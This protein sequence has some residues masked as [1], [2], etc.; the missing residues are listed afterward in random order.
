MYPEDRLAEALGLA[1]GQI[2]KYRGEGRCVNKNLGGTVMWTKQGV[3][4]LLRDLRIPAEKTPEAILDEVLRDAEESAIR[5]GELTVYRVMG[6]PETVRV[7]LAKDGDVV[8]RVMIKPGTAGSFIP[9]MK[10]HA[11]EK[12]VGFWKVDMQKTRF[13]RLGGG[14]KRVLI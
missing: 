1:R 3:V 2:S 8:V 6:N 12:C 10:I 5:R 11:T 13:P 9:G 7:I 14:R 4:D